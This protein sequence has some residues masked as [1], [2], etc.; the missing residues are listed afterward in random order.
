MKLT[1]RFWPLLVFTFVGYQEITIQPGF[2]LFSVGFKN[3]GNQEFDIQNMECWQ[4][5]AKIELSS[6]KCVIQKM[7]LDG[8][9]GYDDS[10]IYSWKK[11]SGK[12]GW[13]DAA[14]NYLV[15]GYKVTL[16]DGEGV[17][18]NNK[19]EE[20]MQIRISGEVKLI[21]NSMLIHDG[22]SLM[23]NMTPVDLDIQKIKVY[24]AEGELIES[25]S[26]KAVIQLMMTDGDGG[27]DDSKIYSWKKRSGK[28]GWF[29]AA[30]NYLTGDYA[31]TIPAGM[32]FSFNNKY[33]ETEILKFE[34][35]YSK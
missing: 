14:N 15:D 29:D 1:S 30:N 28:T 4:G 6:A 16:G 5:G 33:G 18:I 20:P 34:V 12:T 27:Y 9:G 17:S 7:M 3:V 32:G 22:F 31:V 11:R 13:F 24:N 2:G 23:G 35:D 19:T 10:K 21:P 8:D 26:A 25:S